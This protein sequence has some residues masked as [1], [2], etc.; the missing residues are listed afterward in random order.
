[1]EFSGEELGNWRIVRISGAF[2]LHS[3]VSFKGL[4]KDLSLS[5]KNVLLDFGEVSEIDSV[6]IACLMYG[7][8]LF[9]EKN[10]KIRIVNLIP[11]VRIVFQITRCF[12][13]FEIFDET[14]EALYDEPVIGEKVA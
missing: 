8:K 11:E 14:N 9:D 12:D 5:D 4:I 10:Y 3:Y 13:V 2:N 1:M 6:G 7:K